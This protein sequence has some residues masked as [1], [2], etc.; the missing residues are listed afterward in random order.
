MEQTTLYY[1]QGSS[2]KIYQASI[3][4]Q[5]DGFIVPFAYG[6]RGST[7]ATGV[8][9]TAPVPY[10]QAKRI[11]DKLI[12]EKTAKGYTPGEDGTP[13][14]DTPKENQSTGVLPMLLAPIPE[15]R[16]PRLIADTGYWMQQKH[17]G[18]RM[19]L[20]KRGHEIIGINRQ[21]L[22]V[23]LPQTL[24]AEGTQA[25]MDFIMDGESIGDDF[26]VF[27]L[28]EAA[29]FNI[30]TLTYLLR[31]LR[32]RKV[33]AAFQHPHIHLVK[34]ACVAREK[35]QMFR[36]LKAANAE[37]VVFK[38]LDQP[39]TAGIPAAPAALKFKFCETASFLV[40]RV[41]GKRSVSLSLFDGEKVKP[42]GNVTIPPNRAIPEVGAVVEVRFLYAFRES[43]VIYQPVYLGLR[44]DI[45]QEECVVGQLKY[46]AEE[47]EDE[48]A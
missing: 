47:R 44:D 34:T 42:A 1:R 24:V 21:G 28:L 32:L 39:Y 8:K 2:D 27:D 20:R 10:E 26:F 5:G 41:N 13:Y 19:L 16:V 3:Q 15:S 4:P 40:T 37:G 31:H 36:E 11:Y 22:Q 30:C 48:V 23:A 18:R 43:G 17:D 9:T 25:G 45:R 6:R 14:Q 33:L 12:A 35:E 7:L 38:K 29:E 46:K